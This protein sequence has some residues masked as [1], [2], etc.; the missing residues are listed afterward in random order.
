MITDLP[1]K[2]RRLFCPFYF[3]T[4]SAVFY[5]YT[6]TDKSI[7][8]PYTDTIENA[9]QLLTALLTYWNVVLFFN[10]SIACYIAMARFIIDGD[11]TSYSIIKE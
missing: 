1:Y 4:W 3:P 2:L 11:S 7:G 9:F 8:K 6:N 5:W 10:S